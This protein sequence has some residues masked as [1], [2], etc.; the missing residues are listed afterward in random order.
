M[1]KTF[2]VYII[3]LSTIISTLSTN[4][5]AQSEKKLVRQGNK[6]YASE[7]YGDSEI[8][9]RRALSENESYADAVFNVGDALYKQGKYEDA[10]KQFKD[11][12]DMNEDKIK[13]AS[14]Y[15][16]L[17]NSLLNA[18]KLN[19]CIEAYKNSLRLDPSNFEAKYNL[20]YAQDLLRQQQQNQQNDQ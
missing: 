9:Y 6:E 15:F 8:S 2:C 17:G 11:N 5:F 4:C 1:R 7:K 19:Q 3:I 12:V 18:N 16:N 13:K 20:A 14:A 10:A